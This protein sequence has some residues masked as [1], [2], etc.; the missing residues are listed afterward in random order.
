MDGVEQEKAIA[1]LDAGQDTAPVI[2]RVDVDQ[3]LVYHVLKDLAVLQKESV[4][5]KKAIAA[6]GACTITAPVP[7]QRARLWLIVS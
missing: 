3:N 1:A 4:E 6:L 7:I 5:Q 2:V